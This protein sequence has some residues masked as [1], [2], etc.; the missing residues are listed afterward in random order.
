MIEDCDCELRD[1]LDD[2]AE[3]DFEK[4]MKLL[5]SGWNP[6]Q[7]VFFL[8]PRG[9]RFQNS[10]L[11]LANFEQF[12]CTGMHF[13]CYP[14]VRAP[15]QTGDLL[16]KMWKSSIYFY[17]FGTEPCSSC[18]TTCTEWSWGFFSAGSRLCR[19]VGDSG[20]TKWTWCNPLGIHGVFTVFTGAFLVNKETNPNTPAF[21]ASSSI[22]SYWLNVK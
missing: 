3:L 21:L 14:L 18:E 5:K 8:K 11:N 12:D 7:V 16:F 10:T 13:F 9:V 19:C 6:P 2:E 20:F 22:L 15:C 1:A 17:V 4:F